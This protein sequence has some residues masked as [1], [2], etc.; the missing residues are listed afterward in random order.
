ML[1]SGGFLE[2]VWHRVGF[3]PVS[4]ATN[5]AERGEAGAVQGGWWWWVVKSSSA[6]KVSS[7][8]VLMEAERA[9]YGHR[10]TLEG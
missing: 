7:T 5:V 10:G 4:L 9:A 1:E 3:P 6:A 2:A 8:S